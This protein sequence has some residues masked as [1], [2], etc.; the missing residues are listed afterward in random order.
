VDVFK[1]NDETEDMV[2]TYNDKSEDTGPLV[3][4]DYNDNN[5]NNYNGDNYTKQKNIVPMSVFV[6]SIILGFIIGGILGYILGENIATSRY[7]SSI[8]SSVKSSNNTNT[9]DSDSTNKNTSST[10][11]PKVDYTKYVINQSKN[12]TVENFY[13]DEETK[14]Y[15][16]N[17]IGKSIPNLTWNDKNKKSHNISE[18]GDKYIIEFFNPTCQYCLKSATEV[19]KYR[20]SV[21]YKIVSLTSDSG[22]MSPFNK[23][24]EN[25]FMMTSSDSD[26]AQLM[27]NIPYIPCFLY[28][29]NGK[30][31]LMTFG[32]V[33]EATLTKNSEI[34]FN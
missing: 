6:L 13:S 8:I 28:V 9:S 10:S 4:K 24:G 18:L 26:T 5:S 34:A 15:A 25:A 27:E 20:K 2:E 17:V 29:Q 32:A 3:E 16:A 33:D 31:K 23:T 14:G 19:D 7:S 21:K 22:D 1:N 12:V 30:I 11:K